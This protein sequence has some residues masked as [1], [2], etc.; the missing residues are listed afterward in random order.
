MAKLKGNVNDLV[1]TKPRPLVEKLEEVDLER[2]P[3]CTYIGLCLD[4][5]QDSRARRLHLADALRHT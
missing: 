1:V 4:H 5:P 2:S 3:N